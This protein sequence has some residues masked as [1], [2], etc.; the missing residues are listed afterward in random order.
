MRVIRSSGQGEIPDR[1][2]AP[3][4]VS[5]RA[6]TGMIRCDSGADGIVRMEEEEEAAKGCMCFDLW[7]LPVLRCLPRDG[8]WTVPGFLYGR[9]V[10]SYFR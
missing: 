8:P 3:D 9:P 1:R 2:Y 4:G 6:V 5:P 7:K 10:N